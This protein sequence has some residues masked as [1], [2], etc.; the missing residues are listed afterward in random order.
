[1]LAALRDAGTAKVDQLVPAVYA[2]VDEA[3]Y[4]VARYSLWAHLLKLAGDGK[5][6][7]KTL[8]G[9]WTAT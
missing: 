3:L 7:G 5:A 9:K 8:T 6:E 2:E 4:P 1:M